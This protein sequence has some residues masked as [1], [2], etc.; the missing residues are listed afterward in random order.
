MTPWEFIGAIRG[1]S[2]WKHTGLD[3]YQVTM[4]KAEPE[5]DA[6]YGRLEAVAKTKGLTDRE[7]MQLQAAESEASHE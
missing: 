7:I 1:Y 5:N 6:G 3:T 2:F 4:N